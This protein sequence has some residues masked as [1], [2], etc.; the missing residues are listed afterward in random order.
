MLLKHNKYCKALFN[1]HPKYLVKIKLCCTNFW[2]VEA[3][4]V[5]WVGVQ[6]SNLSVEEAAH[7]QLYLLYCIKEFRQRCGVTMN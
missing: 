7:P 6:A 5:C 1:A 2:Y 4:V 3:V